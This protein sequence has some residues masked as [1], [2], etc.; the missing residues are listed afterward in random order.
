MILPERRQNIALVK[1]NL[2]LDS[3]IPDL[4]PISVPSAKIKLFFLGDSKLIHQD[5]IN[6]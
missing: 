5:V 6:S 4:L 2:G 3:H 1:G